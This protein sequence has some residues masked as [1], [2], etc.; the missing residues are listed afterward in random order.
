M[1]VIPASEG[2]YNIISAEDLKKLKDTRIQFRLKKLEKAQWIDFVESNRKFKDLTDLILKSVR[3]KIKAFESEASSAQGERD[4]VDGRFSSL[5]EY[6]L[7]GKISKEAQEHVLKMEQHMNELNKIF[8]EE[9]VEFDRDELVEYIQKRTI[10]NA[11]LCS[12]LY[13][14]KPKHIR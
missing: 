6:D 7:H 13:K 5:L 4:S 1:V 3:E 14:K 8:S 10:E 12:L 2:L 9:E 11:M